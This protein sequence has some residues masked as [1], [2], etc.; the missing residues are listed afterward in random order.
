MA[1]I[2]EDK[3][4]KNFLISA[5]QE[6]EKAVGLEEI[7]SEETVVNMALVF[8]YNNFDIGLALDSSERK[9]EYYVIW[10]NIK[11][12]KVPKPD[13]ITKVRIDLEAERELGI[14]RIMKAYNIKV[15]KISRTKLIKMAID[16]LIND[17]EELSEEEAI[18]YI[19][20]LYKEA[21]F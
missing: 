4:I 2:S 12:K 21:E 3:S 11:R 7:D 9:L 16:N 14:K 8:L 15:K 6:I 20:S 10:R 5:I 17:L 1:N 18:E 19:R 13:S